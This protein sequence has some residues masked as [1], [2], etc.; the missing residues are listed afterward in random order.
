MFYSL[1][2]NGWR[3]FKPWNLVEFVKVSRVVEQELWVMGWNQDSRQV[4]DRLGQYAPLSIPR[5]AITEME[6]VRYSARRNVYVYK[7]LVDKS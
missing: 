5:E 4:V 3:W 6:L 1:S 7:C 2:D